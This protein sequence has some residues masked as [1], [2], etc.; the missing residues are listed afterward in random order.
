MPPK[1]DTHAIDIRVRYPE[2]DAQSV[3]HH[4]AY[5]IWM[6]IARTELL[7]INGLAYKDCEER[8][9][10]FVVVR[11]ELR[12]RRPARYDDMIT[13]HVKASNIGRIKLEHTYE[14][15]R[16]EELLAEATTTLACVDRTGK[17]QAMPDDFLG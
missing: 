17:P 12:Y 11:L 1:F 13:V 8:G 6:E 9:V 2:C 4:S 14:I 10:F 16:G 15:K 3:A 7:R 5:P